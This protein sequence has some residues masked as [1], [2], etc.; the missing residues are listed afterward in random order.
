MRKRLMFA[1]LMLGQARLFALDEPFA[2]V[3]REGRARM[4]AA[5]RRALEARRRGAADGARRGG[6][7]GA[8]AAGPRG[9]THGSAA[10]V[11]TVARP[12]S[13]WSLGQVS[14]GSRAVRVSAW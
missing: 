10:G 5:L 12:A 3:D 13:A 14:M 7:R 2:G 9:P 4:V 11:T 8:R 1:A 6:P